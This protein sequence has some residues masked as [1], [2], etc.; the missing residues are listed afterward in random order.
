MQTVILDNSGKIEDWSSVEEVLEIF[1]F[2]C[3]E[4]AKDITELVKI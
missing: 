2:E 4:C 1:N 3:P